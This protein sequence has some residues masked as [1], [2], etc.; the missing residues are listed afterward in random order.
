MVR[1]YRDASDAADTLDQDPFVHYV[2]I[3]YQSTGM[4]TKDK[5]TPFYT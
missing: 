5:N 2:D 3:H 1:L 4:G